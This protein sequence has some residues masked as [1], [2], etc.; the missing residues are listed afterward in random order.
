MSDIIA[1]MLCFTLSCVAAVHV[2]WAFGG[3]WPAQ[4]EAALARTVVGVKDL[5]KMPGRGVTLVVSILIAVAGI[6]PLYVTGL[7]VPPMTIPLPASLL[8]GALPALL[9]ELALIFLARGTLSYVGYFQKREAEEP[10]LTLDKRY[11]APLCLA[12][13]SGYAF[14]ALT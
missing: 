9:G 1:L 7:L 5:R 8:K 11:Y 13:G 10:F 3:L 2:Y 6:L 4:D 14:L 12:L